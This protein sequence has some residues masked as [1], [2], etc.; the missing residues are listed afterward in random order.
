MAIYKPNQ[1][2]LK[3]TKHDIIDVVTNK[4]NWHFGDNKELVIM[5]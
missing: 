1:L 3:L 5:K 4:D 2:C